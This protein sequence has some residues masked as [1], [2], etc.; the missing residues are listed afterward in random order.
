V[1]YTISTRLPSGEFSTQT[2]RPT[3]EDPYVLE[4]K[5]LYDAIVLGKPWKTTPVDARNDTLLDQ[6]IME[7]LNN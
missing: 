1:T 2:I 6:M 7:A 4:Y 3:F 5:A